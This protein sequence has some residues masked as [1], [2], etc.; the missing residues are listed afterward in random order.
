MILQDAILSQIVK[1]F[2]AKQLKNSTHKILILSRIEKNGLS[3]AFLRDAAGFLKSHFKGPKYTIYKS[4][5]AQKGQMWWYGRGNSGGSW[6]P[7][8]PRSHAIAS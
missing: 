2:I 1:N 4:S 8:F 6:P 3:C 7:T 5:F